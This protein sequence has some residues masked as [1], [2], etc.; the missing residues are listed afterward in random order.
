MRPVCSSAAYEGHNNNKK[1]RKKKEAWYI[2]EE[3]KDVQKRHFQMRESPRSNY[4]SLSVSIYWHIRHVQLTE[5]QIK[6]DV[7]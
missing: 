3:T 1:K 5:S 4:C 2:S 7:K 6:D